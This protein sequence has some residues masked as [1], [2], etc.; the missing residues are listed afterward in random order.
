MQTQ[1]IKDKLTQ[2][3]LITD[4]D[5]NGTKSDTLSEVN[6]EVATQLRLEE[7]KRSTDVAEDNAMTKPSMKMN[8]K[9]L[10]P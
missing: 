8:G 5:L 10:L 1:E 7:S 4:E 6:S 3:A 9:T 2:N